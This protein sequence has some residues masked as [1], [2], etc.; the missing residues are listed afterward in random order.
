MYHDKAQLAFLLKNEQIFYIKVLLKILKILKK[1]DFKITFR[2]FFVYI[3]KKKL[4]IKNHYLLI[5]REIT[6]ENTI[7]G[8]KNSLFF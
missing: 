2:I 3:S 4:Y 7:Y 8:L 1:M 6:L 5:F